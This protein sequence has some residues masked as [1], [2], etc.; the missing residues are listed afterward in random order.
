LQKIVEKFPQT[1]YNPSVFPGLVFRL[2]KP[3]TATLIFGTG[4]MVCTGGRSEKKS[5]RAVKHVIGELKELIKTDPRLNYYKR[6]EYLVVLS[7]IERIARRAP[8]TGTRAAGARES[9]RLG[10]A[11]E[12][13]SSRVPRQW[14]Q[15]G[16][17]CAGWQLCRRYQG[18]ENQTNRIATTPISSFGSS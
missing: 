11:S 9:R 8:F 6:I 15:A 5:H 4:K 17:I 2:K 16:E 14:R 10:A 12:Q 7:G 3:K 18:A 1:E 13:T